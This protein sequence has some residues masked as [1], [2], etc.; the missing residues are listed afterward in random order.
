MSRFQGSPSRPVNTPS[1]GYFLIRLIKGGPLVPARICHEQ[2]LWWA[3]VDGEV[4]QAHADPGHAPDVFR[5]WHSGQFIDQQTYEHRLRL[6]KWAVEHR[7]DHPAANPRKP[8]DRNS[9]PP[10]F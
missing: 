5:I 1:P 8:I 10:V 4:K 9:T 6:K 7:P 3:V 2:G